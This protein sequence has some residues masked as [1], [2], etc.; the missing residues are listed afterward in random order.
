MLYIYIPAL[1]SLLN[2]DSPP[3]EIMAAETRF[4]SQTHT[5]KLLIHEHSLKKLTEIG[6][7]YPEEF[8]QIMNS[9]PTYSC[10]LKKAIHQQSKKSSS[11]TIVKH[12]DSDSFSSGQ[13]NS[14]LQSS[15]NETNNPTI[16]LKVD[17]SNY[18]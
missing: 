12:N 14:L 6:P 18:K 1:I 5:K 2:V 8:K 17:F 10:S 3:T 16:K 11:N 13:P 7:K 4:L 9:N 15:N